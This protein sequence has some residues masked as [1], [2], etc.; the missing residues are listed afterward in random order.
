MENEDKLR[1]QE[2]DKEQHYS[3]L[4]DKEQED[5]MKNEDKNLIIY[6]RNILKDKTKSDLEKENARKKLLKLLGEKEI[7]RGKLK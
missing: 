2:I 1:E 7:E 3:N 5:I 4:A 6:F